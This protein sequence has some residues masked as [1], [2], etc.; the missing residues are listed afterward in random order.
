MR[1]DARLTKPSDGGTNAWGWSPSS[2]VTHD[3][4]MNVIDT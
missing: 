4:S 2:G 1:L 3:G